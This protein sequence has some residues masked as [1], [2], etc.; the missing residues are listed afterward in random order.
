MASMTSARLQPTTPAQPSAVCPTRATEPRLD[1]GAVFREHAALVER[2]LRR[3]GVAERDLP[4]ARQEVFL[5]V[6]RKLA[7]FE[8]RALLSTWLYR[9]AWNVASELRRKACNR[10]ERLE[11]T[12]HHDFAHDPLAKLEQRDELAAVMRALEQL[13]ADKREVFVLYELLE[14]SM[15]E[16]AARVGCPLKTAFSRLYA[17]RRMVLAEVRGGGALGIWTALLPRRIRWR[18]QLRL[19]GDAA[20]Q[21]ASG[22]ML[23]TALGALAALC[24]IAPYAR[25]PQ[26]RALPTAS[27]KQVTVGKPAAAPTTP[28]PRALERL[29]LV[30][31][32]PA[33]VASRAAAQGQPRVRRAPTRPASLPLA[34]PAALASAAAL[35]PSDDEL[36][37][38]RASAVDLQPVA[39]NPLGPARSVAP[40][41]TRPRLRL[42]GP[43]SA[44]DAIEDAL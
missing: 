13:D 7:E 8:H 21:V 33:L 24:L 10:H 22:A 17:A 12:D 4:D 37:L 32:K 38:I 18:S 19:T 1:V 25:V 3:Y 11:S 16:V 35:A 23:Q 36:E 5:V 41:H 29:A 14:L 30:R 43:R 44:A 15:N 6:H 26:P 31:A 27:T 2:A 28:A 42:Q 9:I 20:Q 39:D 34:Q 40:E